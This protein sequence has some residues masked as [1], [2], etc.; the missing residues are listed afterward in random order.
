MRRFVGSLLCVLLL[1]TGGTARAS[2]YFTAP[3]YTPYPP[4]CITLP[5]R[6]VDLYGANA[7][8]FWSGSLWLE[9]VHKI[10]SRDLSDNLGRVDAAMYRVGCAEPGRSVILVELR[11]PAG[12]LDRRKSTIV[13][14]TFTGSTGMDLVVFDLVPEP[15]SWSQVPTGNGL[16]KRALGDY[17]GGWE[18]ASGFTWRYVLDVGWQGQSWPSPFL[19]DY[20]NSAFA[21]EPV[22]Y[23]N[24]APPLINVPATASRVAPNPSLPLNGRLSGI[25]VEP[26][27]ADQGFLLSIG[28]PVPPAGGEIAEPERSDLELFLSWYTFD[29]QGNQLWLAGN[30]R[31]PQGVDE[32]TVPLVVA[33]GGI[34]LGPVPESGL[35]ADP[36]KRVGELHIEARSCNE[37][38]VEYDLSLLDLD[39]GEFD[40]QRLDALETAGYPCRDYEARL[41]S[42]PATPTP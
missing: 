37:L 17:A 11:L 8:R 23:G 9:V 27:A 35:G 41:A 24:F 34:F 19:V 5:F 6:Q 13:L 18:D 10:D 7:V 21:L 16:T 29:T 3:F 38:A 20:Y 36:R 31:F 1:G 25:W 28:N 14:P 26:G 22:V 40:L 30:A 2:G 12:Q 33:D 4:G 32:V 15:N 42:L 39:S